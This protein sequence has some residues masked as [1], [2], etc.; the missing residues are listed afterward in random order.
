M[1]W[2]VA[3][4]EKEGRGGAGVVVGPYV[5]ACRQNVH[6]NHCG[7]RIQFTRPPSSSP[8][9]GRDEFA[10]ELDA[11]LEAE[12]T[13][14]AA[15]DGP[16]LEGDDNDTIATKTRICGTSWASRPG[17]G[18]SSRHCASDGDDASATYYS[19]E[20]H[21]MRRRSRGGH[22]ESASAIF[23]KYIKNILSGSLLRSE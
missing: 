16:R 14:N 19:M 9:R 23:R 1:E 2:K 5:P 22:V 13:H 4:E 6:D 8:D 18:C 15:D 3:E 21:E 11:L 10:I 12:T 17:H 7:R 20:N